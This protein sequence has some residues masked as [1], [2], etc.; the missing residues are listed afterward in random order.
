MRIQ[1]AV[2]HKS[3]NRREWPINRVIHISIFHRVELNVIHVIHVV[4][5]IANGVFP[6]SALPDCTFAFCLT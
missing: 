1:Y 5:I 6:K 4:F 2:V 3:M